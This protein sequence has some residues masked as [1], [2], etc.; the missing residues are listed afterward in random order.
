MKKYTIDD[1]IIDDPVSGSEKSG[2]KPRGKFTTI[3]ALIAIIVVAGVFLSKMKMGSFRQNGLFVWLLE[4]AVSVG[5]KNICYAEKPAS[6]RGSH[7][8]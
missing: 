1:L 2:Q 5:R 7:L 3:I 4:T 8:C 6:Y